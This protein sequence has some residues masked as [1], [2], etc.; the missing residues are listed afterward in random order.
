MAV[1]VFSIEPKVR[2]TVLAAF[3]GML[4]AWDTATGP[5]PAVFVHR[6]LKLVCGWVG[7][8]GWVGGF[9]LGGCLL[10]QESSELGCLA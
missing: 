10:G 4:S 1:L 9:P 6:L 5:E 3:Q 2:E 7:V 8:G